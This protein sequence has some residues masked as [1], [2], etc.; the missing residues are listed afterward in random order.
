MGKG[1]GFTLVELLV[2]ISI[3]GL[4]SFLL[5]PGLNRFKGRVY[6][7]RGTSLTVSCLRRAQ[8]TAILRSENTLCL[9]AGDVLPG[10]TATTAKTYTFTADG[11]T[12]PGGSGTSIFNSRQG[13]RKV[14][15]S[16]LGRVRDE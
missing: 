15:V 10:V 13:Q 3:I 11:F 12:K 14:I 1:R 6:L 7:K 2:V 16:S 4:L 8:A 5:L 9:V